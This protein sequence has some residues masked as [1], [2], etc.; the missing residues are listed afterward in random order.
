MVVVIRPQGP[1]IGRLAEDARGDY[2]NARRAHEWCITRA[3]EK[4]PFARKSNVDLPASSVRNGASERE[5]KR[6][7]WVATTSKSPITRS[8]VD[9][10]L[11]QT[12]G[13][14]IYVDVDAAG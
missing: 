5:G 3:G 12:V 9:R 2:E 8:S 10:Q 11:G 1:R 6:A 14:T 13:K 7:Q 4:S